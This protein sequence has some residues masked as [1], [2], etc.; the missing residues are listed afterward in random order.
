MV[1]GILGN[2]PQK[3]RSSI[4]SVLWGRD[5]FQAK[6]AILAR[7]YTLMR[8]AGVK[9]TVADFLPIACPH[10]G[11]ISVDNYLANLNWTFEI[12]D[13]GNVCLRQTSPPD[14]NS[15]TPH[16]A[17]TFLTDLDII[18]FCGAQGY[19]PQ[20]TAASI[21]QGWNRVHPQAN[22]ALQGV[23]P[24]TQHIAST[25]NAYGA[26][27]I[28]KDIIVAPPAKPAFDV[29]LPFTPPPLPA[30]APAGAISQQAPWSHGMMAGYWAHN[31]GSIDLSP[32]NQINFDHFNPASIGNAHNTF[33]TGDASS[34]SSSKSITPT[35]ALLHPSC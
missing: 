17:R 11:I 25:Q 18:N 9:K 5:P 29:P 30:N 13:E 7:A 24:V 32:L 8:D 14:I 10:I 4:L 22:M 21:V 33:I 2:I 23:L 31:D 35:H 12:N 27:E 15:F 28:P 20:P 6:W 16:I 19:L 3:Y 34:S 26:W 1:L